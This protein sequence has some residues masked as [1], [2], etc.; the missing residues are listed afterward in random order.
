MNSIT[1]AVALITAI[2]LIARTALPDVKD[3]DKE[4]Q[5]KRHLAMLGLTHPV[6]DTILNILSRAAAAEGYERKRKP[7]YK[8]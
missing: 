2:R 4:R 5:R 6:K 7:K 3:F 1:P 8:K